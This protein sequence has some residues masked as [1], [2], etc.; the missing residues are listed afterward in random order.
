M[1]SVCMCICQELSLRQT[2]SMS[3]PPHELHMP[4]PPAPAAGSVGRSDSL[5]GDEAKRMLPP[6]GES[7]PHLPTPSSTPTTGRSVLAHRGQTDTADT[8][9]R[10]VAVPVHVHI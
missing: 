2:H 1:L 4:P 8:E 9:S 6:G 7:Q 5:R 3:A 10:A